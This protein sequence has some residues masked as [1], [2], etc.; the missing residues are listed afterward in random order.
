M[1]LITSESPTNQS[2]HSHVV[3]H[4]RSPV[5]LASCR[6]VFVPGNEVEF[7]GLLLLLLLLMLLL[8]LLNAVDVVDV[9]EDRPLNQRFMMRPIAANMTHGRS[10]VISQERSDSWMYGR[11]IPRGP[12]PGARPHNM[13]HPQLR[14][15]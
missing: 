8:T 10:A 15:P 5:L 14:W 2:P 11:G 6:A 12:P 3:T 1:A 9:V 7:A 13:D 4:G